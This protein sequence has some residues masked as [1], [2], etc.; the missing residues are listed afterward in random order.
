MLGTSFEVADGVATIDMFRDP[1]VIGAAMEQYQ[2][3]HSGP[4]SSGGG[5]N[6]HT[7]LRYRLSGNRSNPRHSL[8]TLLC[9]TSQRLT[10]ASI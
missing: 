2:Q 1:A 10:H 6:V 4:L 7:T 3:T 5:H 9:S 8:P